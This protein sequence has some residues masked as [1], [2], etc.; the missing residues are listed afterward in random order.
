MNFISLTSL[1]PSTLTAGEITR[2]E[3]SADGIKLLIARKPDWAQA[4]KALEWP[5]DTAML[6]DNNTWK[7]AA[8]DIADALN[9][10]GFRVTLVNLGSAPQPSMSMVQYIR[11]QTAPCKAL[12]AVGSGTINDLAKYASHQSGKAYAICGTAPSMNGYLSANAAIMQHGHKQS[13]AAAMPCAALFDLDVLENAPD[14]LRQAG[15]GDSIC[16]PTAQADWLLSHLLLDTDYDPL[17]FKLLA[18]FE[19]DMLAGD[20]QALITTLLLSGLGMT[21]CRGSQPASQGEHLVAHYME[22]RHPDTAHQSYHGEQIAVTSLFMA[23]LQQQMLILPHAPQWVAKAADEAYCLAH[24]GQETGAQVWK[25][26]QAKLQ[27][28]GDQEKLNKR[29]ERDWQEIRGEISRVCIPL[30]KMETTLAQRGAP[31]N[32]LALGWTT[33]QFTEAAHHAHLIRNRFTF[34]DIA[35]LAKQM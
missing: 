10:A 33:E 6:C 1:L 13:L 22:M 26:W 30:T 27:A 9:A 18:P 15:V 5:Q 34:L 2:C 11:E 8:Q 16:R 4:F 23:A 24:F 32:A 14:R 19:Q 35:V 28:M 20:M 25:E 29:L 3:S 12:I 17:P 7:A 21:L 31:R